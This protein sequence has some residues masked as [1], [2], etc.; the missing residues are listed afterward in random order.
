M[1]RYDD[2]SD[3]PPPNVGRTMSPQSLLPITQVQD[4][5]ESQL[6]KGTESSW[7]RP[8]IFRGCL[9][10]P[11]EIPHS[12][13]F[14]QEKLVEYTNNLIY[15]NCKVCFDREQYAPLKGSQR[16]S[17]KDP[18]WNRPCTDLMRAGHGAGVSLIA[19]GQAS[20]G[21]RKII[22]R[23]GTFYDKRLAKI[24]RR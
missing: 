1:R 14:K 3:R 22:C 24:R 5:V 21:S 7:S 23:D 18:A 4:L 11:D 17:S 8:L 20:N 9:V 15:K 13:D 10:R 12:V 16:I 19:N 2:G 6:S